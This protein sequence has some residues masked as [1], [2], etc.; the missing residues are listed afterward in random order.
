MSSLLRFKL[1][2]RTQSDAQATD[3]KEPFADEKKPVDV[4]PSRNSDASSLKDKPEQETQEGEERLID[5]PDI[6][7][8]GLTYDEGAYPGI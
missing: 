2:R 8:S 7:P 6:T 4:V 3:N 1:P 5:E